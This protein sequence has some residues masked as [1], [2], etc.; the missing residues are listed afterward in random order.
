MPALLVSTTEEIKGASAVIGGLNPK[1][2]RH[3]GHAGA[4]SRLFL[5]LAIQEGRISGF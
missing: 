3:L 1:L 4:E 5:Q 2:R